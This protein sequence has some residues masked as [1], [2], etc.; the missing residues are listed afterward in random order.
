MNTDTYVQL[1]RKI[2]DRRALLKMNEAALASRLGL[3]ADVVRAWENGT[4][5]EEFTLDG[6]AAL[7]SALDT[8]IA[9][10]V[11]EPSDN[12][13]DGVR[14]QLPEQ[15]TDLLGVRGGQDYYVYH[16]LVRSPAVPTLIPLVVDV[17]VGDKNSAKFNGGHAGH[18]F[19]YVLEGDVHMKWGDE[20]NPGTADLPTGSS[21]YIKPYIS[22][23]FTANN[24]Q[25]AK[26]LAVNF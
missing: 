10:L 14:L 5:E 20:A 19:I 15:N 1:G 13:I 9:E 2:R 6:I 24:G 8:S 3:P 16:C 11:P 17:L 26:L 23:A 12:L 4:G 18:E 7:A 21:I 25:P 22:H